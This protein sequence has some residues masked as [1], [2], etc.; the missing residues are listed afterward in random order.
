VVPPQ[1]DAEAQC[2]RSAD[3]DDKIAGE[4]SHH[5]HEGIVDLIG[6]N[7]HVHPEYQKENADQQQSAIF[8]VYVHYSLSF[9][10]FRCH[11]LKTSKRETVK[12]LSFYLQ[13]RLVASIAPR[14][15]R[16]ICSAPAINLERQKLTFFSRL[17][18]SRPNISLRMQHC[19]FHLYA[20]RQ[21]NAA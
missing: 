13:S 12:A 3:Q 6:G 21:K 10:A 5:K 17:S 18:I 4:K 7:Q 15:E 19:H 16:V 1:T 9:P 20:F 2:N 8:Y 14:R 11:P